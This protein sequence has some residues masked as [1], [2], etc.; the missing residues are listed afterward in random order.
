MYIKDFITTYKSLD[1]YEDSFPL[2]Q[3]QLIQAFNLTKFDEKEISY[4]SDIIEKELNINNDFINI[5]N[6]LLENYKDT[7]FNESNIMMLFFSYTYFDEFH[8][9]Y[10]K[11]DFSKFNLE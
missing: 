4:I 9:C 2:Y 1:N 7:L 10:I 3:S 11:D 6:K 8:K 5:K